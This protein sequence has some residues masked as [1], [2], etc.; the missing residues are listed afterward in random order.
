MAS[1]LRIRVGQ[2]VELAWRCEDGHLAFIPRDVKGPLEEGGNP[3]H[4][5]GSHHI[6]RDGAAKKKIRNVLRSG[7]F[8]DFAPR[9]LCDQ[10]Y[11]SE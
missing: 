1:V 2:V 7:K 6:A 4:P 3:F 8:I 11:V 9:D 5:Q 10:S